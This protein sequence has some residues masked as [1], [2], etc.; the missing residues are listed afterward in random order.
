[1]PLNILILGAGATGGYF[2]GRL[3]QAAEQGKTNINVRFL[4]REPRA[5]A[6]HADG[7]VLQ[8]PQETRRLR[9]NAVLHTE[10][11]PEYDLV[12]LSCKAYDLETAIFAIYPAMRP[13][14]YVLPLLN[15]IQHFD[16]LDAEFGARRVLGGCCH[17]EGT[18]TDA[19]VVRQMSA[20][21]RITYGLRP[22]NDTAAQAVLDALHTAY[23]QTPVNAR[24][25]K[26]VLLEI[27]EKF[28]FLAT[29]AGMTT[30]MRAA[31]GDIVA[32]DEGVAQISKMLDE[33]D[34]AASYA[35]Y[36][37]RHEVLEGS[38]KI[39]TQPASTFTSSML[40]DLEAGRRT[41]A[42]HI[43]GDML[44]RAR[45]AGQK[46]NMLALAWTHLQARDARRNRE[47]TG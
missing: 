26:Q 40:R 42:A 7:L 27:W 13:D 31:I 16:R 6:L 9:V 34:A 5:Q 38:R 39:L 12:L 24:F 36:A 46:A 20:L 10:L 8:T 22:G 41:E 19:G 28:V 11:K 32:A 35:G 44:H 30:L 43:V 15:G 4:V 47:S 3:A 14:T 17:L 29:L 21:H 2:G 23:Q 1:M 33:C 37:P 25:S 45:A 18:L